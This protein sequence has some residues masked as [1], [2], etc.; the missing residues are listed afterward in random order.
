MIQDFLTQS[1]EV[2][3]VSFAALLAV[4]FVAGLMA[5]YRRV[6]PG[7]L[8][9]DFAAV[10]AAIEQVGLMP[11]S[12]FIEPE[13]QPAAVDLAEESIEPAAPVSSLADMTIR[14]LKRLA[15]ERRIPRYC[16]LK[17]AE[18]IAALS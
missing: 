15:S 9:I 16:H 7:Q 6:C 17:K 5:R 4:Q 14:E 11:Y 12:A 1:I 18:L 10:D 13:P 2:L 3:T 8:E